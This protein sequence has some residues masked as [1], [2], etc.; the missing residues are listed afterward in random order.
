MTEFRLQHEVTSVIRKFLCK[1]HGI[2]NDHNYEPLFHILFN[3]IKD[4]EH[5]TENTDVVNKQDMVN[6]VWIM[7]EELSSLLDASQKL[8]KR[9]T[10]WMDSVR[11]TRDQQ[12]QTD[13]SNEL[14]SARHVQITCSNDEFNRRINAFIKRKRAQVD[15]FNRREFCILRDDA[16]NS[17]ARTDAVFVPRQSKNSLVRIERVYNT[18]S[19]KEKSPLKM[20]KLKNWPPIHPSNNLPFSHAPHDI[21]E[22]LHNLQTVLVPNTRVTEYSDVYVQLRELETRL[23]YLETLSPEYFEMNNTRKISRTKYSSPEPVVI[24]YTEENEIPHSDN[25]DLL[26]HRIDELKTR[27][28]KR[29]KRNKTD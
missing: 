24:G 8:P 3:N 13:I 18:V 6:L 9:M 14:T 23:L 29:A 28:V 16:E 5:P 26:E 27:L 22:R 1:L 20:A 15:A 12:V 17:C 7:L 19:T 4:K 25:L 11:P 21:Q 10:H 2:S